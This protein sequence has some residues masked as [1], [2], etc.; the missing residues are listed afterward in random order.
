MKKETAL[1]KEFREKPVKKWIITDSDG[2]V[3][4]FV[5]FEDKEKA[6]PPKEFLERMK[7]QNGV[8]QDKE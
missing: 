6:L 5:K 2:T 1:A 3:F 7:L 8:R 4:P